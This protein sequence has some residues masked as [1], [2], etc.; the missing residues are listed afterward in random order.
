MGRVTDIV[1]G[2]P[3]FILLHGKSIKQLETYITRFKDKR[4]CYASVNYFTIMEERILAKIGKRISILWASSPQ[5]IQERM[6]AVNRFLERKEKNI[7]CTHPPAVYLYNGQKGVRFLERFREKIWVDITPPRNLNS[8]L[9]LLPILIEE[10][11]RTI[12]LFG[13]DGCAGG[14]ERDGIVATY[15]NPEKY[16]D[17]RG[18]GIV[19]DTARFNIHIKD[20]L[21]LAKSSGVEL[22]NCSPGSYLE[23]IKKIRYDE[24]LN[25]V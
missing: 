6:P 11:V 10:G 25:Y 22:L 3:V 9:F 23:H 7:L 20:I 8:V 4:I 5:N 2:R 16:D 14:L 1:D 13:A 12:I 15:Y 18:V 24:L 21:P 19:R 17:G